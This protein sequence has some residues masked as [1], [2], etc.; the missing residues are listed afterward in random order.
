[1]TTTALN[2]KWSNSKARLNRW[3]DEL[4]ERRGVRNQL[5]RSRQEEQERLDNAKDTQEKSEKAN[6]FLL[7]EITARRKQAVTSIE[8]I[9][10]SALKMVYDKGYAVQFY[11]FE[12]SRK[13]GA[14]TF[15]MEIQMVSPWSKEKPLVT[16]LFGSRGGGG[17]E[18]IAFSLRMSALDWCKYQGPMLLDEAFKSMSKDKKIHSVAKWQRAIA[19]ATG[20]QIIF[21]THMGDIFGKR[22]DKILYVS[23]TNACSKVQEI[24]YDRLLQLAE[25]EDW[26]GDEE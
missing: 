19:D 17:I 6:L 22:A 5:Q 21:T 3:R 15:K 23:K 2:V 1:M 11:N 24:D 9:G 7:S 14:N 18:T 13:V 8:S 20:R 16:A 10:T 12:D 26:Y 4:L 25:E